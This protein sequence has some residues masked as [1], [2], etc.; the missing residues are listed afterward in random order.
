M[1]PFKNWFSR[2]SNR[3]TSHASP[4]T[5]NTPCIENEA[6]VVE[7]IEPGKTG[8]V[9]FQ[10]ILWS[11]YCPSGSVLHSGE[12]VYVVSRDN[13]TLCVEPTCAAIDLDVVSMF[14]LGL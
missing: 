10:S 5:V 14:W 9:R 4:S 3:D 7:T 12:Q 6:I 1:L 13:T 11:A 8:W 2:L